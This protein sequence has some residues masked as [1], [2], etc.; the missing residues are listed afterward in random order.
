MEYAC[1]IKAELGKQ[2]QD[3]INKTL[4]ELNSFESSLINGVMAI[5][6]RTDRALGL[7]EGG[8]ESIYVILKPSKLAI[9]SGNSLDNILNK[10]TDY[11]LIT[12]NKLVE[13]VIEFNFTYLQ[14]ILASEVLFATDE[15]TGAIKDLKERMESRDALRNQFISRQVSMCYSIL[16]DIKNGKFEGKDEVAASRKFL[17]YIGVKTALDF[18]G[19]YTRQI[20]IVKYTGEAY[21]VDSL[22]TLVNALNMLYTEHWQVTKDMIPKLKL[23]QAWAKA[24]I[25]QDLLGLDED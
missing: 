4:D 23:E 1:S 17:V 2:L 21:N 9:L 15:Y 18:I 10:K 5:V 8:N 11:K 22:Y 14:L 24:D 13:N 6:R 20:R 12:F 25:I 19:S 3:D 16:A 7:P